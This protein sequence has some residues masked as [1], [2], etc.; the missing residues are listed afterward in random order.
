MIRPGMIPHPPVVMTKPRAH[1]EDKILPGKKFSRQLLSNFVSTFF[2]TTAP[3][4]HTPLLKQ[5]EPA[6]EERVWEI[7]I[8]VRHSPRLSGKI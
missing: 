5:L 7:M 8:F 2:N 6:P 3:H 1:R 4:T